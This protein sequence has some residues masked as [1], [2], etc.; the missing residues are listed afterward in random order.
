MVIPR[1]DIHQGG[2]SYSVTS[3]CKSLANYGLDVTLFTTDP[4]GEVPP[5][6]GNGYEVEFFAPSFPK[7]YGNS[8]ALISAIN[9]TGR[10]YDI[11]HI[12]NL[13]N[14]I[15]TRSA[16]ASRR[17]GVPYV[18]TP[19]GMLSAWKRVPGYLHKEF[20]FCL[21]D[22]KIIRRAAFIHFLNEHEAVN[23]CHLVNGAEERV[24]PNGIWPHEF[25][26]LEPEIF[27][28]KYGLQDKPFVVFLGRIPPT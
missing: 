18:I 23:S 19:G 17:L 14:F 15:T 25:T 9:R 21:F 1:I 16:M 11:V 27:R 8:S 4:I 7:Q 12:H 22:K 28:T 13:W 10:D 6:T 5:G 2:P 3:L 20:Y 26:D 24:I